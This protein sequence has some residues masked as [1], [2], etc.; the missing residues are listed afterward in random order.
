MGR[1]ALGR[2][3]QAVAALGLIWSIVAY[4]LYEVLYVMVMIGRIPGDFVLRTEILETKRVWEWCMGL[5]VV[6]VL[7]F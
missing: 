7:V 4:G 3:G 1:L 6:T 2:A 5:L